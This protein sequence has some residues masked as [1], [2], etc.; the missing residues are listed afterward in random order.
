M[1]KRIFSLCVLLL[2]LSAGAAFAADIVLTSVG[3]SPDAM[4]VRVVL[5]KMKIGADSEPLL[6]SDGLGARKVLVAVVGGSSKGLGAAG[7][8]KD[9][10]VDRVVELL[11]GARDNGVKVL[12]M[13]IGGEGRRGTL[14]DAFIEVAAP[15]ADQIIVVDGGNDDKIF[16]RLVEGKNIKILT[17][18]NVNGT[19]APLKETLSGWGISAQ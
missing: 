11:K 17:A 18:P 19:A 9:Q 15:W 6:K 10:E 14:S 2:L 4:M 16:D 8:N 5:R 13:H 3:Q 12:V 1:R 7:I